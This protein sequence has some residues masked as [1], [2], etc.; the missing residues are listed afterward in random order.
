MDLLD[1]NILISAFRTDHEHHTVA[2]Q[3]LET[4]LNERKPLRLFP[5]IDTGFLRVVTHPKLFAPP[6]TVA[7]ASHFL[8]VLW[9]AP[10]VETTLWTA[11]NRERW[12]SLCAELSLCGNDCNDALLAAVALDR[13]LR[14]VTFD[15]GF[16]RFP[17]LKLKLLQG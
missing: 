12:L 7:E 14:M 11:T 4:S 17:N 15:K 8:R 9:E 5:T 10:S 16:R 2:K 3:W 6:S 13:G 1:N